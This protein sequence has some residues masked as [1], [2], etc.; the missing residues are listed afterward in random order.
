MGVNK[1]GYYDSNSNSNII[2]TTVDNAINSILDSLSGLH[3]LVVYSDRSKLKDLWSL[4][5]KKSIEEKNELVCVAPFYDTI[6]S[7][8]NSLSGGE[9]SIDVA[10]YEKE[11][12][13]LILVDSLEKYYNANSNHVLDIKS[14][15]KANNELVEYANSLNKKGVSILGDAGAFLFKDHVQSLIDYESSLPAEFDANL[16]G[17]CLYHQKDFD[18]LSVD[19]KKKIIDHHKIAIKI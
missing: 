7:V 8:R 16:R 1:S 2:S 13:S 17:I 9:V 10:K 4:Y 11:E 6:D 18:R 5:A 15:L 14:L 3:A 19:Q 12:K